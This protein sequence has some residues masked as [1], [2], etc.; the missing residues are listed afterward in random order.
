MSSM[1]K[2]SQ[3]GYGD[4]TADELDDIAQTITHITQNIDKPKGP[5]LLAIYGLD[6]PSRDW[7]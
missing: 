1:M 2:S 5:A 3:S 6:T 4:L 7:I